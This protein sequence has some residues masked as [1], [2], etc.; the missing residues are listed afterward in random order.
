MTVWTTKMIKVPNKDGFY[1]LARDVTA[2]VSCSYLTFRAF[3]SSD[4]PADG[5]PLLPSPWALVSLFDSI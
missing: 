3:G 4:I 5:P 2:F 1:S